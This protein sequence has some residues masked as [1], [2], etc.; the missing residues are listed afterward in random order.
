MKRTLLLFAIFAAMT[1]LASDGSSQ[2][3]KRIGLPEGSDY[4]EVTGKITGKQYALYQ[5][6]ADKGDEWFA[7]LES[8]NS[9]VGYSIKAPNGDR[10][11]FLEVS[12]ESGYYTIRVELTSSAARSRKPVTFKL[13]IKFEMEPSKPIS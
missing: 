2:T 11:D 9:Y 4:V 3:K 6:W 12:P 13:K 5:I 8:S 1:V 7:D 10:Y